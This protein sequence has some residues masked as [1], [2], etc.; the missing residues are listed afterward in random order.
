MTLGRGERELGCEW[1][2]SRQVIRPFPKD[3]W[4]DRNTPARARSPRPSTCRM[5]ADTGAADRG[6][7]H[8]DISAPYSVLSSATDG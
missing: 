6:L 4:I 7:D 5:L 3:A 8:L 1:D 2:S